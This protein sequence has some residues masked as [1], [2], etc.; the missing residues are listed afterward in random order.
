MH[1]H[2]VRSGAHPYR[3]AN[4]DGLTLAADIGGDPQ[5][6][7]IILLHGGGQTRHSWR[8]T[9]EELV[10][11]GYRA[12][13]LD[14]RGHGDS[15]WAP[16][17]DY[18]LET[19]GR[20]LLDV[21][22]TLSRKPVVVGASMGGMT[23]LFAAGLAK[24]QIAHSVILVDVVPGLD[25]Q[26]SQQIVD[27]LQRH[28]GG[29]DSLEQAADAV[30]AYNPHRPR[31]KDISGLMKN[32]RTHDDGRL[33]WH[34]DP[35]FF[36]TSDLIEPLVFRERLYAICASIAVP[37]LL[38]KGMYSNVVTDEGVAEFRRRLP[39]LQVFEVSGAG[40]MIT[41]DRNDLFNEGVLKFIHE[42]TGAI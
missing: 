36:T 32:L 23:A 31:P 18:R 42:C 7:P 37:V 19:L 29:F 2:H 1:T 3:F 38:V 9:F 5:A 33:Y 14:A 17:G 34:W 11:R 25:A 6:Q 28:M 40:H 13:S 15:D 16:D 8:Q 24:E 26:G 35:V 12:I 41:G 10:S 22:A 4:R 39:H 27:F 21:I 30:S 20:D